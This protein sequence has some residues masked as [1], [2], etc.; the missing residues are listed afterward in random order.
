MRSGY[1]PRGTCGLSGVTAKTPSGYEVELS[2]QEEIDAAKKGLEINIQK[3]AEE[4][5]RGFPIAAQ[6]AVTAIGTGIGIA[7][8]GIILAN[9][10]GIRSPIK[11]PG[12]K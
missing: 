12:M 3:R 4:R 2:Q 6:A 7:L 9:V 11:L 10:M 1:C 5:G 8:A